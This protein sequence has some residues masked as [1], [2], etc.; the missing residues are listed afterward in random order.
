MKR[1]AT[2][3][4]LEEPSRLVILIFPEVLVRLIATSR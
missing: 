4:A 3:G 2:T 1:E